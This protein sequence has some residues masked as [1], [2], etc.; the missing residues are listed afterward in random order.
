MR[1]KSGDKD[2]ICALLKIHTVEN[3]S[4]FCDLMYEYH[5]NIDFEARLV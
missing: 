1:P 3:E 2:K 4:Q 5:Y